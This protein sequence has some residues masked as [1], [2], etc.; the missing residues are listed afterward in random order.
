MVESK[1]VFEKYRVDDQNNEDVE[2]VVI[3]SEAEEKESEM[4]KNLNV[5]KNIPEVVK[6]KKP[7]VLK[8]E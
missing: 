4:K 2:D 7:A 5:A 8:K 3:K 1:K 6:L